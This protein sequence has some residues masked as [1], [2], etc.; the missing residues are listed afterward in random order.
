VGNVEN[1]KEGKKEQPRKGKEK[2]RESFPRDEMETYKYW[3]EKHD[4]SASNRKGAEEKRR[5]KYQSNGGRT[6]Y[7]W[8]GSR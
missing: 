3:G 5:K 6:S 1:T 4:V 8:M 2:G 7:K